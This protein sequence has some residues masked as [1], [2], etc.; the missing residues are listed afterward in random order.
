MREDCVS[1]TDF[2]NSVIDSTI[3][4]SIAGVHLHHCPTCCT[5]K[6]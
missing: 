6:C 2:G 1:A 3:D 5:L 4:S